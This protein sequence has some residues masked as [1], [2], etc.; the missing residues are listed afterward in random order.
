MKKSIKIINFAIVEIV[1]LHQEN[2]QTFSSH[3]NI[4]PPPQ[5]IDFIQKN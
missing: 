4:L 1:I 2:F 5:I 3:F